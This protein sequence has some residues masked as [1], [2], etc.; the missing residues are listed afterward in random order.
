MYIIHK[1]VIVGAQCH[2]TM[3]IHSNCHSVKEVIIR[4]LDR[5]P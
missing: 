2:I 5:A 3:I 1:N 4:G